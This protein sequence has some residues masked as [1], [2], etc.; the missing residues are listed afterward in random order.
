[1]YEKNDTNSGRYTKTTTK[2][3]RA[4]RKF[5]DLL[6]R[7]MKF[8]RIGRGEEIRKKVEEKDNKY[9][10]VKRKNGEAKRN[11]SEVRNGEI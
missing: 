10:E 1:M 9:G 3:H 4:I 7:C 5:F 8:F 2:T 6:L 11:K